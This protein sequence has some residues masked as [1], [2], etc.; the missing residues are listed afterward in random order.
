MTLLNLAGF[1]QV[2]FEKK[3]S[4]SKTI[5]NYF[6]N[7]SYLTLFNNINTINFE[8]LNYKYET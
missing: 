3:H 5:S 8:Y 2:V 4:K 1:H 6:T 7:M